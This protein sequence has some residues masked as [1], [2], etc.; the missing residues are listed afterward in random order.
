[1]LIRIKFM[2]AISR[3]LVLS[4]LI[5]M[6]VQAGGHRAGNGG[7]SV[8]SHFSTIANNISM[9]WKDIC[10]NKQDKTAYCNYLEDYNNTLDK[11][12]IRYIKIKAEDEKK[13]I[14]HTCKIDDTVREAC[15]DGDKLIVVNSTAWSEIDNSAR[16][17]NL[18]LHEIFSVMELDSSDHY[19][20]SMKFFS[21]IKHKGYDLNKI[22]AHE[23]LPQPC[24]T[25][26][27][28]NANGEKVKRT[29]KQTLK[30]KRLKIK[31]SNEQ[32]R[33]TIE[34]SSKCNQ[35]S[36][37]TACAIQGKLVDHYTEKVLYN[38]ISVSSG[39]KTSARKIFKDF[40]NSIVKKIDSCK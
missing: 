22:A 31:N 29:L 24:S 25:S 38:D 9:V 32:T 27:I 26:I 15:N 30:S 1:M 36:F 23:V 6:N 19:Q 33:Y 28:E 8:A 3:A 35:K 13:D 18:V 21:A 5:V 20:Y 39:S 4:G 12:N 14:D 40:K 17:I 2:K 7:H 11:D 16:K 10:E 34:L 37:V